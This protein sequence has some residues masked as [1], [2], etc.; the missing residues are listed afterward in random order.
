MPCDL[1][2]LD[3]SLC[4]NANGGAEYAYAVSKEYIDSITVASGIITGITMGTPSKWVKLVPNKNQ[5]A[6]Y[7]QTG[8]RP[9]EFSTKLQYNC[10]GFM[11]FAGSSDAIKQVG[12]AIAA[13]CQLV[14]IWVLNTGERVI[15]GLEIDAAATGGFTGSKEGDCRCTPKMLSDTAANEARLELTFN[16]KNRVISP[17]TSLTDAA[18]EAL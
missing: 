5:T 12:D 3:T 14:I 9:N 2:P 10:E 13:C 17:F 8:E 15:Q 4:V 11:Y 6:K 7:D 16:S 1:L 18:I